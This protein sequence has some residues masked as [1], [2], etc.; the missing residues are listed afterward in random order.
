MTKLISFISLF[1]ISS[2]LLAAAASEGFINVS[3]KQRMAYDSGIIDANKATLV[4]L[5]GIY[6]GFNRGDK[7]IQELVKR[8]INFVTM[9]FSTQPASVAKYEVGQK[10]YF[11]GGENVTSKGLA[12]EVELLVDALKIKKAIIVTLSYSGSVSEYL[13]TEKFPV[14]IETSPIGRFDESDPDAAASFKAWEDWFKLFPIWGGDAYIQNAKN[15][16]FRNFWGK[17]ARGY[18]S[19]DPKLGTE[20]NI[21]RMTDGYVGMAKAVEKYD[22]R[23]QNFTTSARRVFIFGENED[24]LRK[25]IQLEA[26]QK[27]RDATGIDAKPIIV[28]NAGHIVP[29]DQP[30]DY[31]DIL[32]AILDN[33]NRN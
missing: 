28:K 21:N 22:M 16:A 15:I 8:K 12:N 6:R 24:G 14:V 7:F 18:A 1:V 13:N 19:S 2:Q 10:T 27:Y 30:T 11:D 3:S 23:N 32:S 31:I 26:V 29:N 33:V 9:N 20:E 25:S 5:P 17:T 4:L